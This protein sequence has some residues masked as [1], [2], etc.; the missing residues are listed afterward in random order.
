M[1]K[2][3]DMT[4]EYHVLFLKGEEGKVCMIG[5]TSH[6]KCLF[7]LRNEGVILISLDDTKLTS[8]A[9]RSI[10][11]TFQHDQLHSRPL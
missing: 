3:R 10:Q 11:Q 8:A 5:A 4:L 9:Q 2:R 6:A 7:K 1:S